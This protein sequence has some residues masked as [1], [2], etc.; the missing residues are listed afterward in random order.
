MSTLVHARGAIEPRHVGK[1]PAFQR[2]AELVDVSERLYRRIFAVGLWLAAALCAFAAVSSLLQPTG[3]SQ[4]RGLI[5]CALCAAGCCAAALRPA[6]VYTALRRHPGLL[7]I[8]GSLV[9]FGAW[10]VGPD[11]FQLFLPIIAVLS[12]PGIATPWR[13]VAA[14]G[15]LAGLGLAA[16]QLLDGDGN[17]AGPIVLLV[18]PLLLWLIVDRIA[19][20]AL[21]LHE[22]LSTVDG[23]P[24]T[25]PSGGA[26]SASATAGQPETP[27][28]RGLP[29]PR[30][31]QVDGVRL[32]ARQLQVILL[33]AEGLRHEEIG[34]CLGIGAVQV[35]RHLKS[36]CR[37]VDVATDAELVTWAT[38]RGLIPSDEPAP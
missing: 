8:A 11:N 6:L 26:S 1:S 3:E 12:V 22:M 33:C 28:P 15:V 27:E 5:V 34:A 30:V 17:L 35:G 36:A 10:F 24:V 29:M 37:R 38:R 25:A 9:G 19:V 31:I 32:T 4:L 20:F 14:A 23:G 13:V 7:L 18:P 2:P 21:R 16:P